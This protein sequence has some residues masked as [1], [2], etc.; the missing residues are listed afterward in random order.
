MRP[1]SIQQFVE[2]VR[3]QVSDERRAE[4]LVSARVEAVANELRCR[5]LD[6]NYVLDVCCHSVACWLNGRVR[7]ELGLGFNRARKCSSC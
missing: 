4:R 5:G 3:N 6:L 7:V 1:A 2:A